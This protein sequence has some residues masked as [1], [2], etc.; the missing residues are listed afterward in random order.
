MNTATTTTSLAS[1]L[2]PALVNESVTYTS[3]VASQ[4]GGGLTG[5]VMFQDGGSTVAT[6]TIVGNQAASS[7][8]YSAPGSHSIT[9]AY[10]GDSNNI[11]SVS[12]P[13]V[14]QINKGGFPSKTEVTTSG[15]P[16]FVGQPATFTATVTSAHGAIPDGEP[17][18]FYNGSIT[19][20]TGTTSSGVATFTTSSLTAAAH[21]IKATYTGDAIFKP[22]SGT[23]KQTVEKYSTATALTSSFNPSNYGQAVTFTATVT[24]AGPAPTGKVSFRDGTK[25]LRTVTLSGGVATLASKLAAGTHPI[26]AEYLGDADN[27]LSTSPVLDQVVQ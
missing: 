18:T 13:L 14:E 3:I 23:V 17:V 24:S 27:A 9:V 20:G 1:S 8:K 4:Y 5:T 11:G 7:A 12:P 15:S 6:V 22:S 10:S 25:V 19:I 21:T 2:N 26:T 16:T